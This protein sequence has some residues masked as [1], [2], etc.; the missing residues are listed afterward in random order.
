MDSYYWTTGHQ[1]GLPF[2]SAAPV[3]DPTTQLSA[4]QEASQ[5]PFATASSTPFAPSPQTSQLDRASME[6]MM[7]LNTGD[8]Q[9]LIRN[10][11]NFGQVYEQYLAIHNRREGNC[12]DFPSEDGA[13][14]RLVGELFQ[15]AHDCSW[16][17][18]PEGSQSV[19]KIK[20]GAYTD[21]E[22]EL[23]LW[24]LLMSIRDAQAGRCR[25]PNYLS[26]KEP[27]YN[28]YESFMDRFAAV[29]HALESS[30]DVVLSLFKDATFQHRLAWRPTTELK[31]KA[32][33]RKLNANRDI[34]NAVGLR[35]TREK[36]ITTN[37]NGDLVDCNGQTYGNVKKRSA[38]LEGEFAARKKRSRC[39]EQETTS[40]H[41]VAKDAHSPSK[42]QDIPNVSYQRPEGFRASGAPPSEF[43]VPHLGSDINFMGASNYTQN[44]SPAM[45]HSSP[46]TMTSGTI[47]AS[48]SSYSVSFDAGTYNQSGQWNNQQVT[49][50]Y[51]PQPKATQEDVSTGGNSTNFTGYDFTSDPR[52]MSTEDD[53]DD[54]NSLFSDA[55]MNRG[56]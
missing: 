40:D 27:P 6:G 5:A 30:K 14:Q 19:K 11:E 32:T 3:A 56:I 13:Q 24:P 12:T 18:E 2:P 7:Q 55:F 9:G 35:V 48:P 25:L 4:T 22:F 46:S 38:A 51:A 37:T 45:F 41:V 33:N 21:L 28:S 1:S 17:Y 36:G 15:A 31:Q 53:T 44:E 29:R 20:N 16:T 23:V 47:T 42:D 10:Y 50:P 34:Q 8:Y 49:N 43:S 39:P 26:N 54:M 52:Y